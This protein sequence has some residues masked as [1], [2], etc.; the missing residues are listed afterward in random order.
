METVLARK[1]KPLGFTEIKQWLRHRHPMILIDRVLDYEP[2]VFL[3]AILAV[4]GHDDVLAGHFPERAIYPGSQLIQAFSQCGIIL[5]QL[6]TQKLQDDEVTVVG[7]IN[8]RFYKVIVPGDLV[9]FS[10]KVDRLYT[11]TLFFSGKAS[12]DGEKVAAFKATIV[13]RPVST[14]GNPLW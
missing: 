1:T 14:L 10:V 5:M 6:S 7:S 2:N 3:E 13:K 4:S 11:D 12:V 9:R 8:S